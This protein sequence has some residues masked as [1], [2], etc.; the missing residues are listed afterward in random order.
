M[1]GK[2]VGYAIRWRGS[3]PVARAWFSL[4]Q[5]ASNSPVMGIPIPNGVG[6]PCER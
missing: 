4:M 6:S 1:N 2:R 5:R 3:E